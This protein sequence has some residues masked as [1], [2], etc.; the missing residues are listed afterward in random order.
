[1]DLFIAPLFG[2][3]G[4]VETLQSAVMTLIQTPAEMLLN[5]IFA[6]LVEGESHRTIGAL[7]HARESNVEMI[8]IVFKEFASGFRFVDA[9]LRKI[10]IRPSGEF[11]FEIPLGLAMTDKN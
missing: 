8:T 4:F 10:D 6:K 9:I 2:A 7:E 5:V 3:V 1:M 11:V